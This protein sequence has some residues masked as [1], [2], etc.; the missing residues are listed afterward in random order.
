M[1]KTLTLLLI[2]FLAFQ[3]YSQITGTVVD[4]N[5]EPMIGVSILKDGTSVG[6][7][8]D[9]NGKFSINAKKGDVLV[10]KYIGYKPLSVTIENSS[11]LEIQMTIGAVLMKDVI[12]MGYSKKTRTEISS[13]VSVLN[14]RKLNDAPANDVATLLQGKVSG[15]QV[16]NSSGE[17]GSGAEIRIRGVSTIKPGN[18][19]PL[20][21]VDG[22]IGGSF[23][24]SDVESITVLKDAGA[25]G[26]YG[27]RANKG[28]I[29]VTTKKAKR[30]KTKFEFKTSY[31]Y[32]IADHGNVKM[33]NSEEF[34]NDFSAEL[35]RDYETHQ[36]D[37]I[38]F[39]KDYPQDLLQKDYDW[40]GEVFK[41][42]P[43]Q[44]YYLSTSGRTNKFGYYISGTYY[45]EKGTY[46]T[47][48]FDKINLRANTDLQLNKRVSLKNN[49]N[50]SGSK[51]SSYDYLDMY[52]SY[53][54]V[55]WDNPY[56]EDGTPKYV[57]GKN[58][59][60]WSRDHINPIHSIDNSDYNYKG[61]GIDYDMVFNLKILDWLSFS[62]S[63][64]L[65]FGT[66]KGHRF[67]SPL[68]AGTFHNKG[69]VSENQNMWFGAIST[70]LMHFDKNF[71]SNS[72]DGLFG[73]EL[74]NGYSEFMN[75][76]GKGLPEGFSVP[77]VASSEF[78]IG[79]S[80][81]KELFRSFISQVN[82]N[83]NHTYFLTASYR[84]DQ[85][86]N[87]P[88]GHRTAHFPSI[89]ASWLLNKMPFMNSI[90][91][92][93]M[94]KLR[95]SFGITGDPDIGASRFLGLYSLNT[96][97][98][99]HPAA[100]PYQLANPDLTWE[101][102]YQYNVGVDLGLYKDRIKMTVDLYN[103]DTKDLLVLVSQPLSQGF[104]YRWENSGSVNN[105]GI[106]LGL[107]TLNIKTKSFSWTTDFTFA[108]NK[109]KLA[110]I[111]KPF[112]TT[113]GGVSQIYRNGNEIYTFVLPKWLGVDPQTGGPLWE[114][115][116]RDEAGNIISRTPTSN[117]SEAEPQEVGKALPDF[118]GGFS[119]TFQ[120]KNITLFANLAFQSGNDIYNFTRVF[121]DN[122]GHE[123]YYNNMKPKSDWSRWE[124][125]GDNATHP[126]MQNNALSK[127]PSSRYLESGSF[128]KLRT[129]NLSYSLPKRWI[130]SLNI[131]DLSLGFSANNL[132]TYTQFWGQDPEVT[133]KQQAWSM[134]GVSDFKYPNNKQFLFNINLKF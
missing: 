72:I 53:L 59:K 119:S 77:T 5:Q 27:A 40:V 54:G 128:I 88:S 6:T 120:Y 33:M 8:T 10:F 58:K 121:M 117:Y 15:V 125:P 75:L 19:E 98:N 109:N 16:V 55:P 67:V 48:G 99:S 92:I 46:R 123:P 103:N 13:A 4:E 122:D 44:K 56:N 93:N 74:D 35:Y 107:S 89:S 3:G 126:S 61:V 47:T 91:A 34:F 1:K 79:G 24:P 17:P 45:N 41:P 32:N 39:Y 42:A 62:S 30:Q 76:E 7:I 134:P 86:S 132:Y 26:M 80:R 83:F 73:I 23:D 31:G 29:V 51:G 130:K 68:A 71:G 37:K 81:E 69:Y 111:A 57:D 28:V 112:Y 94:L 110:G 108:K 116:E 78:K 127:E 85:T 64:R 105:K 104:E 21:V 14:E 49:I 102:T 124:K 95:A 70:N 113:I 52:Y 43:I 25:T 133:L 101:K 106:E 22:I 50:I 2:M 11:P 18:A 82:Y 96:Q 114:K 129:L 20:Y 65:S 118:T 9:A 38:K 60:W 100:T 12:V 115:I 84:I 131:E 87:F 66:D 63:N 36:I 97:Y 90:N